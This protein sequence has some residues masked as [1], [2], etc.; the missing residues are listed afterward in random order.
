[1]S[2]T[3]SQSSKIEHDQDPRAA[4]PNLEDYL[5]VKTACYADYKDAFH[6]LPTTLELKECAKY[7]SDWPSMRVLDQW[8]VGEPDSRPQAVLETAVRYMSGCTIFKV[9]PEA[10]LYVLDAL[11]DPESDN[12]A[13]YVGHLASPAELARA[14]SC[15]A[16]AHYQ[17]FRASDAERVANASVE[18]H[19]RRRQTVAA[20]FGY[21]A[22]TSLRFALHHASESARLGHVSP[23]VLRVGF[24]AREIGEG[25]GVEFSR[26]VERAKRHRPL[27]R[28]VDDRLNELYAEARK[29]FKRAERDPPECVCGAEGC[30]TRARSSASFK[31]CSGKCPVDLKPRYCSKQCQ[32]K[33]WARHK[34]ICKPGYGDKHPKIPTEFAAVELFELEDSEPESAFR[35]PE[36]TFDFPA[37]SLPDDVQP[38]DDSPDRTADDEKPQ[39]GCR[40]DSAEEAAECAAADA[41]GESEVTLLVTEHMYCDREDV[42][43]PWLDQYLAVRTACYVD[44]R[45]DDPTPEL[46][47]RSK[48]AKHLAE[49]PGQRVIE[50]WKNGD[51][52]GRPGAILDVALRYTSGTCTVKYRPNPAVAL[53]VLGAFHNPERHKAVG[54]VGDIAS[55]LDVRRAH[56]LAAHA[57]YQNFRASDSERMGYVA[58]YWRRQ[59]PVEGEGEVEGELVEGGRLGHPAQESLQLA[60]HHAS[61]SA[62]LGLVSSIVLR[63]GFT[64]REIGEGLP[65]V[66]VGL[67]ADRAKT[68]RPLWR[69]VGDRLNELYAEARLK[70]LKTGSSKKDQSPTGKCPPDLKPRYCSKQCQVKDWSRHKAICKPGG[71]GKI[72]KIPDRLIA[73]EWFE[74]EDP[75]PEPEPEPAPAPVAVSEAESN[76][77]AVSLPSNVQPQDD[78]PDCTSENSEAAAEYAEAL[79]Q[80]EPTTAVVERATCGQDAQDAQDNEGTPPCQGSD[81]APPTPPSLTLT[82]TSLLDHAPAHGYG[83]AHTADNEKIQQ[84]DVLGVQ[85]SPEY[86]TECRYGVQEVGEDENDTQAAEPATCGRGDPHSW[87]ESEDG[88][89]SPDSERGPLTPPGLRGPPR[90]LVFGSI[91][92]E[93]LRT[94]W[95]EE[96]PGS[97]IDTGVWALKPPAV[98]MAPR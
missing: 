27:W 48:W 75:E 32:V 93:Y 21:P 64:A 60:L 1:M 80:D 63:L 11:H 61:E 23:I 91:T 42:Q 40:V 16:H 70:T 47:L 49:L 34:T 33:D 98:F 15:A 44:Y 86:A 67:L 35:A 22:H 14:H 94:M 68:Y 66:D 87:G 37:G 19:Y 83:L 30:G 9:I 59:Q 18:R 24:T 89:S 73:L 81:H 50:R 88:L 92:L 20:G 69:A 72:P 55:E 38:Q 43:G 97:L 41:A 7:L 39:E 82:S 78:N 31:A 58:D 51:P 77:Q 17:K 28:A 76:L 45:D 3:Q 5:A 36:T 85:K 74:L 2:R 25:F 53:W 90:P 6:N 84:S 65:G 62:R 26:L 12:K 56:A 95:E 52:E 13:D 10:A 54:Y 29:T 8:K 4:F 79:D 96:G 57:H 71:I 46:V